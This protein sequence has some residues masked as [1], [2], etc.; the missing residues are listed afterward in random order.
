MLMQHWVSWPNE[1]IAMGP[2]NWYHAHG[3]VHEQKAT[4]ENVK[5]MLSS[6]I[7]RFGTHKKAV[8]EQLLNTPPLQEFWCILLLNWYILL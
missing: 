3:Y 1:G 2:T 7:P 4:A 8:W 5:V 6:N